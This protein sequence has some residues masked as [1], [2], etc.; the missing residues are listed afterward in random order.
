MFTGFTPETLAFLADLKANNNK[1]WFKAHEAIYRACVL[2]PMLD[3]VEA[4]AEPMLDIDGRLVVTAAVGKTVSRIYRD[5]RFSKDKSP[6]RDHMWCSFKRSGDGWQDMPGYYFE[7]NPNGYSYG[8][9]MYQATPATMALFRTRLLDEP[10]AFRAAIATIPACCTLNGE[11]YKRPR[12]GAVANDLRTWYD[13]KSFWLSG[14]RQADDRLFSAELAG[15][16]ARDFT[17]LA[18][19]YRYL[20]GLKGEGTW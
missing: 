3:L 19:L 10:E 18:P 20:W 2:G 12:P 17:A 16:I 5:T 7:I 6:F 11:L 8:M 9:G 15:D 1:P 4:L 14:G 13:R